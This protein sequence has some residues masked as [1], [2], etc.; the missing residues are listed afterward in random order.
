MARA[1]LHG[2]EAP[3]YSEWAEAVK[4]RLAGQGFAYPLPHALTAALEAVACSR[5]KG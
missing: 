4:R 1:E 2:L 3:A 5:R